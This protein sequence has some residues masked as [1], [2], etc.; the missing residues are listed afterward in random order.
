MKSTTFINKHKIY[1]VWVLQRSSD[2]TKTVGITATRWHERDKVSITA[3][4]HS[5]IHYS[6]AIFTLST[7]PC[8]L[9]PTV[10]RSSVLLKEIPPK[11]EVD[12]FLKE[13][14]MIAVHLLS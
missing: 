13:D 14:L 9:K 5:E 6:K 2:I 12:Q 1:N 8:T 4:L 10:K 7:H 3:L 11:A